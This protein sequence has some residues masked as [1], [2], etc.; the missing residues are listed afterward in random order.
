MDEQ[1]L[2]AYL[3][4]IQALLGCPSGQEIEILQNHRELVDQG[5]VQVML[6]V[7]GRLREQGQL[8]RANFLMNLAGQLI[9]VSGNT[10]P[11]EQELGEDAAKSDFNPSKSGQER[12]QADVNLL[13][14]ILQ[15]VASSGDLQEVYLLL[16]HHS[17]QL[18][19]R[20]ARVL[21]VW[22]EFRLPKVELEQR[23]VF[24]GV[25]GNFS[26]LM[27]EFPLG[28]RATNVEIAIIGYEIVLTV[29]TQ[30]TDPK[31]WAMV[32]HNLGKAYSLRIRGERADNLEQAI[33]CYHQALEEFTRSRFPVDWAMTQNDL[34][35]A[36]SERI[37]GGRADNLEQAI[38]CY[39]QALLVFTPTAPL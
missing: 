35:K 24:A 39:Q 12:T 11:Q 26:I 3:E 28:N 8:D 15:A 13:L 25:I 17:A 31:N 21:Q 27:Q 2:N 5:L 30:D 9:E 36:Y 22:A 6:Q 37:R 14:E 4:L 1:R 34:G 32:Q 7:A 29:Y 33:A 20:F 38:T 23:Q 18:D 19:D 10:P 16:Q